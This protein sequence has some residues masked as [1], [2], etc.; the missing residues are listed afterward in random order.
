VAVKPAKMKSAARSLYA[1]LDKSALC[2]EM[3]PL[4][5]SAFNCLAQ[6]QPVYYLS[7]WFCFILHFE[8]GK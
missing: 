3:L 5:I 1:L 7:F 8:T 2:R 6:I 4:K